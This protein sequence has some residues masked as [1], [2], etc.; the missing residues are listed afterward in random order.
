MALRLPS[1]LIASRMWDV[2]RRHRGSA[3]AMP[4]PAGYVPLAA[5]ICSH[6]KHWGLRAGEDAPAEHRKLWVSAWTESEKNQ[7]HAATGDKR[8]TLPARD[9]VWFDDR[10]LAAIF[11]ADSHSLGWGRVGNVVG[12]EGGGGRREECL[13]ASFRNS[14]DQTIHLACMAPG[15]DELSPEFSPSDKLSQIFSHS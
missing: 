11:S 10:A 5:R 1:L 13:F 2:Q 15:S 12:V 8:L 7:L 4:W 14:G 9:E 6:L 3:P